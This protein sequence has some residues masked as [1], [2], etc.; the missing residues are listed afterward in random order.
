MINEANTVQIQS[1]YV[2]VV[3]ETVQYLDYVKSCCE[4]LSSADDERYQRLQSSFLEK[5][6]TLCDKFERVAVDVP[7]GEIS[8]HKA[9]FRKKL[10]P[11]IMSSKIVERIFTKPLGYPG[12][13]EM[14]NMLMGETDL[15]SSDLFSL[16]IDEMHRK[17]RTARAHKNRITMV[18]QRLADEVENVTKQERLFSVLCIGC[19]PAIELQ[20]FI[21][22]NGLS[23][24][25]FIH[26]VDFNEDSIDNIEQTLSKLCRA[27]KRNTIIEST[28]IHF[29]D[30]LD[31]EHPSYIG[32]KQ[33]FDMVYC[34]GLFD[35]ISDDLCREVV[36]FAYSCLRNN[37]VLTVTN[38]HSSV[39]HRQ[40]LEHALE[41]KFI[42]RSE[43]QMH[44]LAPSN[45]NYQVTTDETG[46]N[47][48]LD[49]RRLN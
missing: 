38:V 41:W 7:L 36:D 48:F 28:Y 49:A 39:P 13:Y 24:N 45:M 14:I 2:L 23:N 34:A 31:S 9:Y 4:T 15:S 37:G 32:N 43:N 1:D 33:S 47:V 46:L 30:L 20:Q 22:N 8:E 5:M 27:A 40:Y 29:P 44:Q 17:A 35:Y 6:E 25:C 12:D 21:L 10:H 18:G 26:V 3:E 42:Y 16:L 11:M 19:G